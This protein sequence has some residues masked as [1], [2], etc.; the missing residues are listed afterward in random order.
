MTA[1]QLSNSPYAH[2]H[3]VCI[4]ANSMKQRSMMETVNAAVKRSLGVSHQEKFCM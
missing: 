4:D 2:A 1:H 3:N